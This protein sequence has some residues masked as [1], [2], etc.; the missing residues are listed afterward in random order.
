CAVSSTLSSVATGFRAGGREY[1]RFAGLALG[2]ADWLRFNLPG[3]GV[4]RTPARPEGQRMTEL[5]MKW[6]TWS[7]VFSAV[8]LLL[9]FGRLDLLAGFVPPFAVGGVGGW[10]FPG[11]RAFPAREE[12]L[13]PHRKKRDGSK[14][15]PH[16][17]GGRFCGAVSL[18]S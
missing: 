6:Q 11:G 7:L 5:F 4:G 17:R 18:P 15:I 12:I 13:D 3:S 16:H 8:V 9:A 14:K 1:G 10:V 2:V